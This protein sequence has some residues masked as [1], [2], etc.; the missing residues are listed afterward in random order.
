MAGCERA[1]SFGPGHER[2]NPPRGTISVF[3]LAG[4]LNC[5]VTQATDEAVALAN[6]NNNVLVFPDPAGA[7]YVN[8]QQMPRHGQILDVNGT[9]FLPD[10]L[11]TIIGKSMRSQMG[12]AIQRSADVVKPGQAPVAPS[13]N[14]PAGLP[15]SGV[16]VVDAGHGGKDPGAIACTGVAEKEIVLNVALE[17]RRRLTDSGLK[18]IMTRE[19]DEFIDL[20]RR[21]DIA[22]AAGADL[23]VAIHAD[24]C[25]GNPR[26]S[27]HTL[28]LAPG[29]DSASGLAK[30]IDRQMQQRGSESRGIQRARFKVLVN[31][32]PPAVLVEIGYLSNRAEASQL[33]TGEYRRSVAE[34]IAEGILEYL[35]R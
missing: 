9:I 31:T 34:G 21:S 11:A 30:A 7:V 2:L 26:A 13:A 1:D 17:V 27:G 19:S 12:P 28:Y 23:F 14:P 33:S 10:S 5:R 8:G 4:R 35:R 15:V 18:V 24:S 25:P 32:V 20:Y 29:S 6:G 3:Q 16:V 22:N